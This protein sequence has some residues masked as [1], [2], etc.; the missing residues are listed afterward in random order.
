MA[1]FHLA[2][3]KKAYLDAILDGHKIVESRFTR[4]HRA[5]FGRISNG[6]KIFLKQSSGPVCGAASVSAVKQFED[7]TPTKVLHIKKRY[8]HLIRAGD[9]FWQ[10]KIDSKFGLL[11]WLKDVKRIE[12][13]QIDKKDWRAWVV[14]TQQENFGLLKLLK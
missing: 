2:I 10:S 9:Q 5:P 8:N 4:T 6:D 3:L 11:V 14:L 13:I 7:L 1:A 12:P